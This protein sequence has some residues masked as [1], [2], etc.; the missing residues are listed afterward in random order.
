MS[1]PSKLLKMDG[2]THT[3]LKQLAATSPTDTTMI[4]VVRSALMA[5]AVKRDRAMESSE[6]DVWL[7]EHAAH[8]LNDEIEAAK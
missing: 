7:M 8:A 3:L 5:E 2:T 1:S 4:A 6:D